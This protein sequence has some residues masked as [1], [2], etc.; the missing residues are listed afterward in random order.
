[1]SAPEL[2]PLAGYEEL[3][4]DEMRA[5][6]RAFREEM[7][8]RRTVR[9]YADRPVPR[10]LIED[11]LR[12]AGSAPSGANLQPW[13]FVAVSERALK[14]EFSDDSDTARL[15]RLALAHIEAERELE[16]RV[17]ADEPVLNTAFVF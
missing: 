17:R 14:R 7:S 2:H 8:R 1:M 15:Q 13:H 9:D 12:T 10:A 11:C 16:A 3:P 5:R 4:L 6:A